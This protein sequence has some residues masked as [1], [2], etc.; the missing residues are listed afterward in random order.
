MRAIALATFDCDDWVKEEKLKNVVDI[1]GSAD[2]TMLIPQ[3]IL[4]KLIE[5]GVSSIDEIEEDQS[6][7]G[8]YCIKDI[9]K[10]KSKNG[11]PYT[12]IDAIGPVGKS[13]KIFVWYGNVDIKKMSICIST[14]ERS[15][16]GFS[17]NKIV[18]LA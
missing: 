4:D 10:K 8:W 11:K 1:V 15:S 3:K 18:T 14:L 6:D 12:L 2:I 7:V 9:Q 17:T 16:F 13:H 5:K